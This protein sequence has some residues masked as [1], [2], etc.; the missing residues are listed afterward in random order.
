MT[1]PLIIKQESRANL[2][3]EYGQFQIIVF[4]NN[5]DQKEH[6]AL[7]TGDVS[8]QENVLTRIHSECLTGDVFHSLRCDCQ[9]QL[10]QSLQQISQAGQGVLL[11]LRHEGRGIGL[12]NKIKA[13]VLQ[14]QGLDTFAANEALGFQADE[15][16]YQIAAEILKFLKIKSVVVLTN[17]KNKIAELQNNGI[18]VANRKPLIIPATE[19][20]QHYLRAKKEKGKHLL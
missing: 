10:E 20:N 4:S 2:P 17:N 19:H 5:L 13:Y 3:T 14:D 16:S 11:Y 18:L 15:R 1:E 6:L 8:A 9:K 12:T 7:V